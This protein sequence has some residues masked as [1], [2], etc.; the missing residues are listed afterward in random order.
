M[1]NDKCLFLAGGGFSSGFLRFFFFFFFFFFFLL[2]RPIFSICLS[3]PIICFVFLIATTGCLP[4]EICYIVNFS[5]G[6]IWSIKRNRCIGNFAYRAC[7]V[8]ILIS[9]TYFW[10]VLNISMMLYSFSATGSKT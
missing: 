10:P 7:I 5:Y 3:I 6:S 4:F 8:K 2:R 1:L 9:N